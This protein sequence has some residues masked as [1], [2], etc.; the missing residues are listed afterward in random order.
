M[1]VGTCPLCV[2]T[3]DL[4]NSHFLPAASY[5]PQYAEGLKVNEPMVVT[6]KR[7]FQ[8]S[9][10]I[11]AHAFCGDCEDIFNKNGESW[12]MEKLANLTAFPLRDM[13]LTARAMIDEPDFKVFSCDTI[14]GFESE[15]LIHFAMGIFWKSAAR[16]WNMLDGPPE[17]IELGSYREPMRQFVFGTASFPKN[18]HLLTFIEANTPVIATAPPQRFQQEGCHLFGFYMNGLVCWLAVG[19]GAPLL[20]E[21]S[22][23]ATAPGHPL[24]VIPDAGKSMIEILKTKLRNTT[25]SKGVMKTLEEVRMRRGKK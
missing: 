2:S 23:T 5:K 19:K 3:K 17:Q 24:F 18:V 21:D 14:P 25:P 8:S 20:F 15:K 6:A 13:I 12:V 11:T 9:R 10:H 4:V 16:K 22:S 7:V 1:P